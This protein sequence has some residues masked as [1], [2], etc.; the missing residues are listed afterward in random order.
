[1]GVIWFVVYPSFSINVTIVTSP[2]DFCSISIELHIFPKARSTSNKWC[3]QLLSA[4]IFWYNFPCPF[5]WCHPCYSDET[6]RIIP[7][8]MAKMCQKMMHIFNWGCFW[9]WKDVAHKY[10][11]Q[12]NVIMIFH[13]YLFTLNS[14]F[15]GQT[16]SL[17]NHH[18]PY[19]LVSHSHVLI[20]L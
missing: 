4:S 19:Y 15:L 6:K 11:A 12:Q 10:T 1:M 13:E 16:K 20:Y 2:I 5:T 18:E 17:T 8:E 7:C 3:T 9:L 14:S